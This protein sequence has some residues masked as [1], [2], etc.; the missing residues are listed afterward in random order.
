MVQNDFSPVPN[1]FWVGQSVFKAVRNDF[2]MTLNDFGVVQN[3]V[4]SV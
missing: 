4:V 3:P 2:G 1:D